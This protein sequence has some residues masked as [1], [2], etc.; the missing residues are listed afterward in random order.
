MPEATLFAGPS[1]YGLSAAALGAPQVDWLP[2]VRRGDIERLLAHQAEPGVIVIAD[3]VF[4]CEPAVS[5]AEIV[6]AL[7]A[8]WQ[9][10][11]VASLG[12]IRAFEL[13]EAGMRGY[14]WVHALFQRIPDLADDELC[15]LHAPQEPWFP[16]SEPLVNLRYALE[17]QGAALGIDGAAAARLLAAARELWFGER[18]EAALRGLMRDVAGL[19]EPRCAALWSWLSSH[20]VKTLDLAAL[21]RRRPWRAVGPAAPAPGPASRQP[22]SPHPRP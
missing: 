13:R 11:G 4:Q 6:R 2:P 10:W 19:G 15:L 9:V 5:H 17:M 21:M 18:S 22:A 1:S 3:G 16:L 14:G 12:A 7:D 20:R 8:G